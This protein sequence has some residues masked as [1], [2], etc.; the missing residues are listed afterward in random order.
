MNF[1]WVNAVLGMFWTPFANILFKN[2]AFCMIQSNLACCLVSVSVLF[3]LDKESGSSPSFYA[4]LSP[5]ALK[6]LLQRP[7]RMHL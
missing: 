5:T 4:L 3:I 6:N 1:T 7:G 2:N